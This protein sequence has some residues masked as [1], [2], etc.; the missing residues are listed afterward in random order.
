MS[1]EFG[2]S[3]DVNID[4]LQGLEQEKLNYDEFCDLFYSKENEKKPN[5][6]DEEKIRSRADTMRTVK[7]NEE[8]FNEYLA[9]L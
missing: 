5:P 6:E 4:G 8:D 2:I 3:I 7:I 9:K 1:D